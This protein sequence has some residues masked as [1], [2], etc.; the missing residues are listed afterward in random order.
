MTYT[1]THSR[2]KI[3]IKKKYFFSIFKSKNVKNTHKTP[4][5][6]RKSLMKNKKKADT[7]ERNKQT[8]GQTRTFDIF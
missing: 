7:Y 4:Y 8:N 1:H 2:D 6:T 5:T 3:H